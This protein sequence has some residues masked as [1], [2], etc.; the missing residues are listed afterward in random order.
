[1]WVSSHIIAFVSGIIVSSIR[2]GLFRQ[3]NDRFVSQRRGEL[4]SCIVTTCGI[5]D[6]RLLYHAGASILS[7]VTMKSMDS[8][9]H[10]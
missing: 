4:V 3:H 6:E 1:M 7:P 8:V 10:E 2:S 5:L 9:K